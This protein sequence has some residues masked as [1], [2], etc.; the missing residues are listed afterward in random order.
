M[1]KYKILSVKER[2]CFDVEIG[3]QEKESF[4][5]TL[6][7][8]EDGSIQPVDKSELMLLWQLKLIDKQAWELIEKQI[9]EKSF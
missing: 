6:E 9:K 7:I 1:E 4:Y 8:R 3:V 5:L 2:K